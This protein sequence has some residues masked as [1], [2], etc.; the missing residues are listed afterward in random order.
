MNRNTLLLV[1]IFSLLFVSLIWAPALKAEHDSEER[2][3]EKALENG[4]HVFILFY[5]QG[6][7]DSEEMSK[8][9]DQAEKKWKDRAEFVRIEINDPRHRDLLRQ[10]SVYKAPLTLTLS[11]EGTVTGGFQ[12]VVSLNELEGGFASSKMAEALKALQ[13]NKVIFFS[14]QN[15]RTPHGKKNLEVVNKLAK[16]LSKSVKVIVIDPEDRSEAK[17]LKQL[18]ANPG[19]EEATTVVVSKNGQIVDRFVGEVTVKDLLA[20]FQKVLISRSGCG[21][22]G[23]GEGGTTCD[24]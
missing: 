15:E 19:V 11:P 5:E 4:K 12:G 3:I 14:V 22:T 16:V 20:S 2:A 6:V 9:F 23:T 10:Y 21:G 17:L 7:T 8:I 1:L 18:K 13:E 24:D